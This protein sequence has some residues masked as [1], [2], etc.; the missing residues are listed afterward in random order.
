VTDIGEL[1]GT[2]YLI[3]EFLDGE[4]LATRIARQ[5]HLEPT[6]LIGIMLPILA[7]VSAGHAAG[8][9]HRDLKPQNIFLS[10]GSHGDVSP[11]VLDF[12]I[13]KVP[14]GDGPALSTQTTMMFGTPEY[15]SPEQIK[16]TKGADAKSDQYSL[17]IILYE[18]LVGRRPFEGENVLSVLQ[19]IAMAKVAS[20]RS[21]RPSIPAGLETIILR[22]MSAERG[23]RFDSVLEL[24]SALLRYADPRSKAIWSPVFT[25]APP[26]TA[27]SESPPERA[28]ES[29]P[30]AGVSRFSRFQEPRQRTIAAVVGAATVI[31]VVVVGLMLVRAHRS[32]PPSVAIATVPVDA[33][34]VALALPGRDAPRPQI[35]A[36]GPARVQKESVETQP[37]AQLAPPPAVPLR[38]EPPR[39]KPPAIAP[40]PSAAEIT[41]VIAEN[42][43]GI[44]VCYQ[45]AVTRDN[46]LA[47]GK[48]TAKVSI[49]PS[50]RVRHVDMKGPDQFRVLLEPCI[51][52]VASRW[53]FPPA[54]EEYGAEFP[55]VFRTN[56]QAEES[57]GECSITIN[58]IP[59]SELWIDGK[60][61]TKHTPIV[62]YRIPCGKHKL[63]FKRADMQI[64][65]TENINVRPGQ[66]F[67]QRYT[68]ATE[69]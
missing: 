7:G 27:A 61:T 66:N 31:A 36:L 30:P 45:R 32:G 49:D 16:S 40:L 1:Q 21:I 69:D 5:G 56:D 10:R 19:A 53:H 57:E 18:A 58:S 46:T 42:Q 52:D 55:L 65:Q 48:L 13:S 33:A 22:A 28:A 8:V 67:K 64:D 60:A 20:P 14:A 47:G 3:M 68:L 54:A 38:Q 39:R 34:P 37:A 26:T 15:M 17:G 9:V 44:K 59:W 12:G 2:P 23:R 51:R 6:E 50:G 43:S 25:A 63:N 29:I 4:D 41:K 11:K 35:E 62:D 24:G